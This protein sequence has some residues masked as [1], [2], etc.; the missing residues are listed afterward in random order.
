[1]VGENFGLA[2]AICLSQ[3]THHHPTVERI[4]PFAVYPFLALA[5]LCAN[6]SSCASANFEQGNLTCTTIII[7]EVAN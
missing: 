1:M 3:I 4:F 6:L 2:V 5:E 7:L